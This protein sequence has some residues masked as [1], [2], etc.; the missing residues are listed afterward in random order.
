MMQGV[1][2]L[3]FGLEARR[4]ATP[5]PFAPFALCFCA[6]SSRARCRLRQA[7]T[8][9]AALVA[10]QMYHHHSHEAAHSEAAHGE[11]H[12]AGAAAA[13]GHAAAEA[14]APP[15]MAKAAPPAPKAAALHAKQPETTLADVLAEARG[16]CGTRAQTPQNG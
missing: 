13:H 15:T 14:H 5:L 8:R 16:P 4:C 6:D 2:V 1:F 9:V 7:L 3:A 10:P 11:G 12:A